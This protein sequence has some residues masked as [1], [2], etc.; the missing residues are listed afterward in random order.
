M[1]NAGKATFIRSVSAAKPKVADYPFTTLVPN[2]GVVRQDSNRS[3]VVADIPGLIEGAADGAGLGIRF[4][5]HLERC[6]ILLHVV[7]IMPVDESNPTDNAK[8]IVEEL[9]K[10]SPKL[11]S[12]PRWLV[13]N[14]VD[15]LLEEEAKE[16]C[17]KIVEELEWDG[18]VYQIS[19]F[20]KLGLEPLCRSIMDYLETLPSEL[21]TED[22][23]KEVEFKW[24]T[25]HRNTLDAHDDLHDDLDDDEDWD[26]DDYDVDVEY[27]R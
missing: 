27:R 5:K 1:P 10:Y 21:E 11:A 22:E 3:F 9:E 8:A 18:P 25:Y 4:L 24:D 23:E 19:A 15:L 6:R 20:Q 17:D 2:L 13:F 7:D 14:K 12:K 16:I 26:E